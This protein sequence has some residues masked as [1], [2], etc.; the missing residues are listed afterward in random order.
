MRCIVFD[1]INNIHS[2]SRSRRR[3]RC[4]K[5][6]LRF[7]FFSWIMYEEHLNNKQGRLYIY[8]NICIFVYSSTRLCW[9][10]MGRLET[11]KHGIILTNNI[12]AL[13][14]VNYD[15]DDKLWH[16]FDIDGCR[17]ETCPAAL[18]MYSTE[19]NPFHSYC[20]WRCYFCPD[21]FQNIRLICYYSARQWQMSASIQLAQFQLN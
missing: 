4:P 17:S 19:S 9:G 16:A 11:R 21:S 12:M 14:F 1:C 8:M 7:I 15:D 6:L 20:K 2:I 5:T 13:R 18:R 10:E 3:A